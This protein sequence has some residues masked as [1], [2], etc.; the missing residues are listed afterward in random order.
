MPK[1]TAARKA[2][3]SSSPILDL[4]APT[5]RFEAETI[6]TDPAD[7]ENQDDSSVAARSE[8]AREAQENAAQ[9]VPVHQG[10]PE[11]NA[12]SS[13]SFISSSNNEGPSKKNVRQL[14]TLRQPQKKI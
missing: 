8:G 9:K 5:G 13:K 12:A 14:G 10:H 6:T 3:D 11:W 2:H 7:S 4:T 1:I